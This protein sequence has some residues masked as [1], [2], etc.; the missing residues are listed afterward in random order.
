[1]PVSWPPMETEANHYQPTLNNTM[2]KLPE[3][4]T[5]LDPEDE[6][7]RRDKSIVS[8]VQREDGGTVEMDEALQAF[9]DEDGRVKTEDDLA[10][11]IGKDKTWVSGMLKILSLPLQLQQ[12]VG[13]SQLS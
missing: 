3:G 2:T 11:L 6:L 10:N 8:N 5:R 13:T 7:T 9:M 4:K 12:K 1:M